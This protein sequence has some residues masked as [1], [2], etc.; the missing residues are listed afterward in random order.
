MICLSVG[1]PVCISGKVESNAAQ[2]RACASILYEVQSDNMPRMDIIA[3][4]L[5][6]RRRN[7]MSGVSGDCEVARF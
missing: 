6:L 2:V 1:L 3:N 4:C 5:R 7:S